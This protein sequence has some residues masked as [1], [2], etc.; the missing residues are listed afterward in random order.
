MRR[1][2]PCRARSRRWARRRWS[3]GS[4][5]ISWCRCVSNAA[6]YVIRGV[7]TLDEEPAKVFQLDAR[8]PTSYVLADHFHMQARDVVFVGASG[9]TRWNRFIS[10]LIP[11]TTGVLQDLDWIDANIIRP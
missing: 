5:P 11:T 3:N 9:I 4:A 7:Q 1:V 6:I 2:M 10:Q 8:S